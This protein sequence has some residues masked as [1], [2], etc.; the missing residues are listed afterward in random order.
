MKHFISFSGDLSHSILV[1]YLLFGC[2]ECIT[3]QPS[4]ALSVAYVPLWL[5]FMWFHVKYALTGLNVTFES[6]LKYSI[7][8]KDRSQAELR[9][10]RAF[11]FIHKHNSRISLKCVWDGREVAGGQLYLCAHC[12]WLLDCGIQRIFD[13]VLDLRARPFLGMWFI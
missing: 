13:I 10:S 11:K 5:L 7:F 2:A 8:Q 6:H 3:A 1:G 9:D 4:R 12:S